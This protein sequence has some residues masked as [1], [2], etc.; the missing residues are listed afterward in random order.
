MTQD[1][2]PT[3]G[4]SPN[5]IRR[6]PAQL[7]QVPSRAPGITTLITLGCPSAHQAVFVHGP[8]NPEAPDLRLT[9][10]ASG[11]G[12]GSASSQSIGTYDSVNT[13]LE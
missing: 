2:L 12:P 11:K 7:Y 9:L 5:Y 3:L 13:S 6:D 8:G 10:W 4:P 1:K